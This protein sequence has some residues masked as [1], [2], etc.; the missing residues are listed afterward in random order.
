[1]ENVLDA[2][3]VQVMADGL[4]KTAVML[5]HKNTQNISRW[6]RQGRI[7]ESAIAGTKALLDKESSK[8]KKAKQ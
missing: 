3:K 5:G 6:I 7:P 1:M 8:S 2:L 4:A